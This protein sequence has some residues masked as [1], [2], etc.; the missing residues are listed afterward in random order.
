MAAS[1]RVLL[2]E[3]LLWPE[4][5]RMQADPTRDPV[6]DQLGHGPSSQEPEEM[7]G[8]DARTVGELVPG[9]ALAVSESQEHPPERC[10][11]KTRV[12]HWAAPSSRGCGADARGFTRG[13][14]EGTAKHRSN[15]RRSCFY[16]PGSGFHLLT[17]SGTAPSDRRWPYRL[18]FI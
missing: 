18:R 1:A 10:G 12:R 13:R 15:D 6:G 14:K 11:R 5:R 16:A 17:S 3:P 9:Q 2:P 4:Q 7:P 8:G